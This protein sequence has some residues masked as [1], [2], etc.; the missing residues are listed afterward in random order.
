MGGGDSAQTCLESLRTF[1]DDRI[2]R[3]ST[4]AATDGVLL[5]Q[6]FQGFIGG[7]IAEDEQ[8]AQDAIDGHESGYRWGCS[9][10]VDGQQMARWN[11]WR[12]LS[13]CV[14]KRLIASAHRDAGPGVE[15]R[16]G[17]NDAR[18]DHTCSTC[19]Q[20]DGDAIAWPCYTLKVMALDWVEHV[21]Y[22][23]EWRPQ[24]GGSTV[25]VTS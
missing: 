4:N 1:A 5:V 15:R 2:P 8:I 17:R 25:N 3:G 11:P 19:G 10:T 16:A 14:S 12:V 13:N 22:R 20:Y 21:D 24:P 18:V 6:T 9:T 23:V 7:R